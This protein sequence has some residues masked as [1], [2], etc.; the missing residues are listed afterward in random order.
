MPK[1][2]RVHSTPRRTASKNKADHPVK[3]HPE[4]R[5]LDHADAFRDLEYTV[6]GIF[7]MAEIAAD[8]ANGAITDER[9]EMTHFAVFRLRDMIRELHT[10]YFEDLRAGKAV[11]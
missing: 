4:Q 5:D 1:A 3:D 10:K 2:N 6:S 7:C 11:T 8:I 9:I